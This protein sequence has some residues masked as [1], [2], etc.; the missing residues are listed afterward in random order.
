MSLNIYLSTLVGQ[1]Q[2]SICENTVTTGSLWFSQ[3]C[4]VNFIMRSSFLFYFGTPYNS[5]DWTQCFE[6]TVYVRSYSRKSSSLRWSHGVIMS[7]SK[8][9][10][11]SSSTTR[12]SNHINAVLCTG[13]QR[14]PIY[15]C[16]ST[17]LLLFCTLYWLNKTLTNDNLSGSDWVNVEE[18]TIPQT[19][20]AF[21]L[22]LTYFEHC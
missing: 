9:Q 10:F 13:T 21:N 14:T 2:E 4:S 8:T 18:T 15:N 19:E 5:W 20:T 3:Q 17:W 16:D 11:L 1:S 7:F 6:Y 12:P 22:G